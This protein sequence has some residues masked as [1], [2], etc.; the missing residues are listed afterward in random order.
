[1]KAIVCEMCGSNDVVKQDGFYVCQHCNTKYS[2]EEA[3][4]LMVTVDTAAKSKTYL[5]L[6]K[7][8]TRT[9]TTN[10]QQNTTISYCRRIPIFGKRHSILSTMKLLSAKSKI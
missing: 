5:P 1:M 8:R 3:K 6:P 10:R 9:A 7:M 4:K 2:V